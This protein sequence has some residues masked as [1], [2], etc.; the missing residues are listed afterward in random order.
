M[1][2]GI[3]FGIFLI[4][5]DIGYIGFLYDHFAL[6]YRDSARTLEPKRTSTKIFVAL[7]SIIFGLFFIWV[8]GGPL[9]IIMP[10]FFN[11]I[12]FVIGMVT[13]ILAY[14]VVGV[15]IVFVVELH[16]RPHNIVFGKKRSQT[17]RSHMC[18]FC[19][20]EIYGSYYACP[21]CNAVFCANDDCIQQRQGVVE[22]PKC[23][24]SLKEGYNTYTHSD[25]HWKFT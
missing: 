11:P 24:K 13:I 15:V 4:L 10:V 19:G 14:S 2:L 22:C 23:G 21:H 5:L 8:F 3:L 6:I 16:D 1:I 25:E 17:T 9:G 7:V 20:A 18:T 12:G